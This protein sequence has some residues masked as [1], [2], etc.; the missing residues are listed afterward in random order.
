MMGSYSG[1]K[2]REETPI[3]LT[4]V[5]VTEKIIPIGHG[6]AGNLT[7]DLNTQ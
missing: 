7:R 6:W 2:V 4:K 5:P 1:A 3:L